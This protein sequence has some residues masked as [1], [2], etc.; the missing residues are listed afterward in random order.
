MTTT[1]HADVFSRQLSP[2]TYF[3]TCVGSRDDVTARHR[4]EPFV[5]A[6][7]SAAFFSRLRTL[8]A[9]LP[10]TTVLTAT[11]DY[12]H[13]ICRTR[14]GFIDDMEFRL[15][16]EGRVV[17]IRSAARVSLFWDW[18]VNRRRVERLRAQLQGR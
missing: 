8:L 9:T 12:L 2:C 3:P 17:H 10:R 18:G 11:E 4:V 5:V 15:H 16:A 6:G 7:D 13:A 1:R 14:L